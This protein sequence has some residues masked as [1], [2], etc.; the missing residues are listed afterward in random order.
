MVSSIT[1][2]KHIQT[3][4]NI[5]SNLIHFS[6]DH[7]LIHW[8]FPQSYYTSCRFTQ[9]RKN[10]PTV[11]PLTLTP[12]ISDNVTSVTWTVLIITRVYTNTVH[13]MTYCDV[14]LRALTFV[15][16]SWMRPCP[17]ARASSGVRNS[18]LSL[19]NYVTSYW[20]VICPFMWRRVSIP[21]AL[22]HAPTISLQAAPG[23]F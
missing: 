23:R 18:F 11:A 22:A 9:V 6:Q 19:C 13:S 12:N 5:C 8:S 20:H 2:K 15:L 17:T 14:C 21:T 1:D 16:H 4:R 10:Q 3:S 7:G